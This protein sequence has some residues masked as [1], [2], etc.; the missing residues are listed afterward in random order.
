MDS[1]STSVSCD[2]A[3]NTS[4]HAS[5]TCRPKQKRDL[6]QDSENEMSRRSTTFNSEKESKITRQLSVIAEQTNNLCKGKTRPTTPRRDNQIEYQTPPCIWEERRRARQVHDKVRSS[7]YRSAK[8]KNLFN[9]QSCVLDAKTTLWSVLEFDSDSEA[10]TSERTAIPSNSFDSKKVSSPDTPTTVWSAIIFDSEIEASQSEY[11][12]ECQRITESRKRR[13]AVVDI[14][15]SPMTPE[16][17]MRLRH[18]HRKS[19]PSNFLRR[20]RNFRRVPGDCK[21]RLFSP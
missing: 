4:E 1:K 20:L 9:T 8:S 18:E 5:A 11:L 2:L 14:E 13:F 21:K 16:K 17:K 3:A 10:S 19:P 7:F 6:K 15:R 12:S